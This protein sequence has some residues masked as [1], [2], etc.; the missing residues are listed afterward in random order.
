MGIF[1]F[2]RMTPE[3]LVSALR[4]LKRPVLHAVLLYGSAAAGDHIKRRSDFN[5]LI[6]AETLFPED[7]RALRETTRRWVREGHPPPMLLTL[8]QLRESCDVF[9]I[10]I[11]DIQDNHRL[12]LGTDVVGNLK[13]EVGNLRLQLEHE[14][15]AKLIQLRESYLLTGGKPRRVLRLVTGSLSSIL[16][17]ARGALRLFT[18]DVPSQKLEAV[19]RLSAYL[20]LEVA[21][22]EQAARLREGGL[23]ARQVDPEALFARYLGAVEE[24][25]RQVDAFIHQEN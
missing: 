20:A 9:P 25:V 22:F 15:K 5:L 3:D 13:V 2:S 1:S 18:S 16:V 8:A 11:L 10:E 4:S 23:S 24:L 19:R 7:L 14:L 6:V 21:V 17:L 12:L